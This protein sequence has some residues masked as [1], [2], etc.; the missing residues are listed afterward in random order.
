MS[1][2]ELREKF[3]K[4]LL[5]HPEAIDELLE[6]LLSDDIVGDEEPEPKTKE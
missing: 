3:I 6:R 4:R 5:E 1:E 2:E